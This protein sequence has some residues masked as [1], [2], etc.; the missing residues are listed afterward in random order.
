MGEV[1]YFDA[2]VVDVE[3][4]EGVKVVRPVNLYGCRIGDGC[5]VGPFVEIQRDVV[6][7][8]RIAYPIPQL[9]L[10]EGTHR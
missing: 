8:A 1:Q 10:R 5:F 2:R 6:V 9:H 3:F 7:G 4:G